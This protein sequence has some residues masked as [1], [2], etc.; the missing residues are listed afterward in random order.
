[1]YVDNMNKDG[2]TLYLDCDTI[3]QNKNV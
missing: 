1:M 3:S 2:L